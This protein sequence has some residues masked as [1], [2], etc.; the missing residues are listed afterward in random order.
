[1]SIYRPAGYGPAPTMDEVRAHA[2][3]HPYV[4]HPGRGEGVW[5]QWGTRSREVSSYTIS[6]Q[7]KQV[8]AGEWC[9]VDERHMPVA[10]GAPPETERETELRRLVAHVKHARTTYADARE[11]ARTDDSWTRS[12]QCALEDLHSVEHAIADHIIAEGGR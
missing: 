4:H 10:I 7:W 12:M 9:A 3:A 6:E 2:A 1:M 8:P 5:L 11:K